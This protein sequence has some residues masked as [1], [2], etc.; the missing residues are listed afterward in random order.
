MAPPDSIDGPTDFSVAP[1]GGADGHCASTA[2]STVAP[3][4]ATGG[5]TECKAASAGMDG[6]TVSSVAPAGSDGQT[7][8]P[9]AAAGGIDGSTESTA[10]S[11]GGPDGWTESVRAADVDQ[12][13]SS[14][15]N[16]AQEAQTF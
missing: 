7:A 16:K 12:R 5:Q 14:A 1:A 13:L 8:S 11:A 15:I 3:T 2:E 10:A 9:L 4:G 6:Q